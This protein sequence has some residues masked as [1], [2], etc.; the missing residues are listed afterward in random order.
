MSKPELTREEV[1]QLLQG[2]VDGSGGDWD[3]DDFALGM[4]FTDK[5]LQEIQK[6]VRELSFEF[7][8]LIKTSFTNE[9]GIKVIHDLI[10]EL[11]AS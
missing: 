10:R 11:R 1:A 5:R 6:R 8:P 3:W 4:T 2:F 9:E 7:P